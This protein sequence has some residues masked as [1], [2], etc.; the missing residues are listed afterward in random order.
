[1]SRLAAFGVLLI[2]LI[3]CSHVTPE[4]AGQVQPTLDPTSLPGVYQLFHPNSPQDSKADVE[5][6]VIK[7]DGTFNIVFAKMEYGYY[8]VGKWTVEGKSVHLFPETVDQKD[9]AKTE[10][11]LESGSIPPK[12]RSKL[13]LMLKDR[14]L[15]PICDN[16]SVSPRLRVESPELEWM[17]EPK[18]GKGTIYLLPQSK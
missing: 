1:M 6:L 9:R 14:L 5:A 4:E 8:T 12:E 11:D 3:G 17:I 10:A 7:K 15:T 2:T 13:E 18:F 16:G